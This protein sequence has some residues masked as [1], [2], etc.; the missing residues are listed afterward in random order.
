MVENVIEDNNKKQPSGGEAAAAKH[1]RHL[2]NCFNGNNNYSSDDEFDL[3][4][5]SLTASCLISDPLDTLK[6]DTLREYGGEKS[7]SRHF[8]D[9]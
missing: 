3:F 5:D 1:D 8:E 9:G 4:S 7:I 2:C 6:L